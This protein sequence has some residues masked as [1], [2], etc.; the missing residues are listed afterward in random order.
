MSGSAAALLAHVVASFEVGAPALD[1][2][3]RAFSAEIGRGLAGE[4][5]SLK[6]LRT[7]TR[8]PTGAERGRVVVVDWGGT[9]ARAGLVELGGGAARIVTEEKLAFPEALKRGAPE[10][11]F[12]LIAG[13]VARVAQAQGVSAAPLAFV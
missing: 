11:V 12:D 7:F 1:A 8:Q 9:N 6:M 5:G 3:A 2:L 13:T 10:P 4:S